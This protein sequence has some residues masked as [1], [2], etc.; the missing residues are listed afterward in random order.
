MRVVSGFMRRE[1]ESSS[2]RN[3]NQNYE[4]KAFGTF[5]TTIKFIV[6]SE[7]LNDDSDSEGMSSPMLTF[8]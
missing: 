6:Q 4:E 8:K 7:C 3:D 2:E 1:D 5:Y